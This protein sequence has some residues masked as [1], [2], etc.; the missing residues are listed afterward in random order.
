MCAR[1]GE[2]AP[3]PLLVCG[4]GR[5]PKR[6]LG[7]LGGVGPGAAVAGERRRGLELR[8]DLGVRLVSR[9]RKVPCPEQRFVRDLGDARV[10]VAARVTQVGVEHRRQQRMGEADRAAGPLDHVRGECRLEHRRVGAR[11]LQQ[12]LRRRPQR[13][14]ERESL[15]RGC[16]EAGDPSPEKAFECL[17]YGERL[18]RVG[19]AVEHARQLQREERIPARL[20]VDAK[21]GLARKRPAEAVAEQAMECADAERSDREA[22]DAFR[23]ERLLEPRR[24][25]PC[26]DAP[27]KQ[28]EHAV[29]REAAQCECERV[30]RRGVEPLQ[31]VDRDE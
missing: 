23:V 6:L 27:G 9:E 11:A 8:R 16:G 20:L 15:A 30:C 2:R 22:A 3:P 17:R 26:G 1:R 13:R 5:Q 18:R 31:V 29:R 21:Q 7:E 28:Q 14:R 19:V 10:N 4:S 25:R 24:R 12:P